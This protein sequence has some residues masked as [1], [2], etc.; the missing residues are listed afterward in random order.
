MWVIIL[1]HTSWKSVNFKNFSATN[2]PGIQWSSTWT[3]CTCTGRGFVVVRVTDLHWF[4]LSPWP[5]TWRVAWT[6]AETH[7]YH[8][9]LY[10]WGHAPT[11]GTSEI[12]TSEVI[13]NP[14]TSMY[15][16]SW[17]WGSKSW[18][19]LGF[20]QGVVPA[21]YLRNT[22]RHHHDH[23]FDKKQVCRETAQIFIRLNKA[24]KVL[25]F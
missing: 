5:P 6:H 22:T 13:V 16:S 11:W 7:T 3:V 21:Q 14:M 18:C 4:N 8:T 15:P 10:M 20:P 23:Q 24:G 17:R 1:A 12:H 9:S 19:S 2:I 25:L